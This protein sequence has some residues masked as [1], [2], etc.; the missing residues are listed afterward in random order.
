VRRSVIIALLGLVAG[1][2]PAAAAPPP[3]VMVVFD[4]F[5]TVSLLDAR[6]AIDAQRYPAFATLGRDGAWFPYATA[7]VD[8]TGRAMGALLTGTTPERFHRATFAASPNNLF[9]L[10]GR[11]Y[12]IVAGEEVS[13]M[14]P[15]ALCPNVRPQTRASVLHELAHGRPERFQRWV[16]SIRRTSRPT[17]WFKHVLLP[18]VPLHYLPSGRRYSDRPHEPIPGSLE[19]F[20]QPWLVLEAYQRH[21]LQLGFTDRLLGG[22]LRRLRAEG[23]YDRALIVVTAD[24]GES[25]GRFGDRHV[26]TRRNAT[27]IALTPLFVKVP[28]RPGGAVRRHVRTVDVLPSIARLTGL[29]LS[30][31]TEGR[32]IFGPGARGIPAA[33][34]MVE[35]SGGRFTLQLRSLR[36]EARASLRRKL[37]FF[38]HGLHAIG[39][40]RILLGTPVA[41]WGRAPKRGARARI[42]GAGALGSVRRASGLVPVQVTGSITGGRARRVAV[43]VDGF[44]AATSPTFSLATRRGTLFSAVLPEPVLHEGR[45]RV[46]VLSISSGP[47]GLRLAPLGP[48]PSG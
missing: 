11:R 15:R 23:L 1:A 22:L 41:L 21:L 3:V 17:F 30:W 36:R 33:T 38:G 35:R 12:R 10:L 45:N 6:G 18:H 27:D 28:G 9:T 25:F 16:R 47:G 43:A 29:R 46:E 48:E 42:D 31:P 8:E 5:P 44:V 19:A 24:N 32:P 39:P 7:T 26:I 2:A 34:Q 40:E 20:H 37:R 13:S 14:C 4:E